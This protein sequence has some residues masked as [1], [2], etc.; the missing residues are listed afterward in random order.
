MVFIYSSGIVA[1]LLMHRGMERKKQRKKSICQDSTQC[2]LL[3]TAL[4]QEEC[5]SSADGEQP[6]E[7]MSVVEQKDC[8]KMMRIELDQISAKEQN[9]QKLPV[10]SRIF[11][12]YLVFVQCIGSKHVTAPFGF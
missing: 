1:L 9:Q 2:S 10:G 6:K 5:H 4:R 11:I 8:E 12:S 7:E 3:I